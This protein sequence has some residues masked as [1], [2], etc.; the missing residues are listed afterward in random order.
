VQDDWK[1]RPNLTLNLGVRYN[2]EMP[3][4]EKYNDQGEFLPYLA[5]SFPL[6]APTTL[7]DGTVLTSITVPPFGYAG[8]GGISKYLTPPDYLD[9]E[10]RLGMA[11]SPSFLRER[12]VTVRA[13]YGLT[14]TPVSGSN[15]LPSPDFGATAGSWSPT[16][17][18]EN[19]N[20]IM[21]LGEN[22]P[23]VVPISPAQAVGAPQ[24][25]LLYFNS[26]N[27]SLAIP[28][29]GFAVSNNYHTPYVQNWNFT[30][31]WQANNS[32]T[33]EIAYVGSK[34][35]RL[36]EP[37]ENIDPRNLN[38]LTA[39]EAQNINT[40]T[41]SIPDPLGRVGTNGK[42]INVQPGSLESP[43]AGFSSLYLMYDASANSHREAGYVMSAWCTAAVMA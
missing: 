22:G 27:S 36:F 8:R 28:G 20:Y 23:V 41:A 26:A 35:T 29:G 12:R 3:R 1:I 32:T 6:S 24:N 5:P 42:V 15:R 31:A 14:H 37:R 39:E 33:V 43:F 34:G 10:P 40:T 18:Q 9:F 2:L 4:T 19:P 17:G 11:W 16:S 13:G 30:I 7:A 25:G 21:R 38:L